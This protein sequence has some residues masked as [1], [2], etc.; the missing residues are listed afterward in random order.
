MQRSFRIAAT[1]FTSHVSTRPAFNFSVFFRGFRGHYLSCDVQPLPVRKTHPTSAFYGSGLTSRRVLHIIFPCSSVCF[2]GH[3]LSRDAQ[4]L[5]VRKTHPTSS[6]H[7]S[8][9]TY[10]RVLH[11]I[12]PC[13]SVCFRG[14]YLSRDVQPLPVRKT[15]PTSS[16]H[17]SGL[18]S[19]GILHIIFP[20]PSVCF[21]GHFTSHASRLTFHISSRF[22]YNFHVSF[23]AIAL[24]TTAAAFADNGNQRHAA[25]S[26]RLIPP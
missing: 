22:A 8:G 2:R 12:F 11:I 14:H 23:R 19:R 17:A 7:A 10:E 24:A 20:C 5:P 9:L 4:P 13:P 6:F 3:Y 15:H 21:R 18:T 26:S 25:R 16:F 1:L